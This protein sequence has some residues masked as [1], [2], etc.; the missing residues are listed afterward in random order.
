MI[1]VAKARDGGN[2]GTRGIMGI[3]LFFHRLRKRDGCRRFRESRPVA[4]NV[5]KYTL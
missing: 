2:I 5:Q 4:E 3:K 1:N